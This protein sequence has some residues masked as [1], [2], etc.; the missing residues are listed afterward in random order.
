MRRTSGLLLLGCAAVALHARKFYDDDP[1]E[2][3]PPL[4]K[5]ENAKPRKLDDLYDLFHH[6]LARPGERSTPEKPIPA[7]GVNTL[8]DVP[9][10]NWYQNRHGMTRMSIDELV[11]GAGNSKP[12][13]MDSPWTIVGVKAEGITPGFRIK[14][15][16]GSRYFIK[17]DPLTN[18]EMST[19][20]DVLVAKFFH[21]LGYYV[22][23]NYI[24]KFK[25]E[26]L[27]VDPKVKFRDL[28][29]KE[30]NLGARDIDDILIRAA[31]DKQ[32]YYRAEASLLLAGDYLGEF[33]FSGTRSD[34][35]ND[36]VPHEHRRDLRGLFVFCAWLGHDDSR[37][38]N[39]LDFLVEEG[40]VKFIKHHLIDFGSTLGSAST[41]PN[42]GRAGYTHFFDWSDAAGQFLSLSL[43][44][45]KWMRADYPKLK[46]VGRFESAVFEPDK[47]KTDYPNSAFYNRLPDD[48]FWAARQVMRFTD[49]DIRAIVKT[50]EY[51]DPRAEQWIAK[52]LIERR[53]KIGRTYFQKVLPLDQFAVRDQRL[54]FEDL[55]AVYKFG[56][57]H[58]LQVQWDRFDNQTATKT[59]L[60][61]AT[62][63]D[64]PA[65]VRSSA[66]GSYFAAT[67]RGDDAKKTVTVYV[68][69]VSGGS[70]R[71][72][73]IE[74]TW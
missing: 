40:G 29:G 61:G 60:D 48:E 21:A 30:R 47:Y 8:G 23:Q 36:V 16:D 1:I 69:A 3:E 14:D 71:V 45:P 28:F 17:F 35:P 43:Y 9:N 26:H 54:V 50:G 33:R 57:P 72:V 13:N 24:V 67:I 31:V 18:P 20:A 46:S 25:R 55:W 4:R 34:D 52:C 42:P 2:R 49:E 10:S 53:D 66:P 22:P 70:F 38:I 58:A 19:A 32:G 56:P 37:A 27:L 74:R 41:K 44:T 7:R 6:S 68:R 64:L 63:F 62:S 65:A 39:T 12:P 11:T 73:G 51:S 15:A 59:A 5:V